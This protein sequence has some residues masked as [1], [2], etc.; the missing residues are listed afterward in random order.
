[1]EDGGAVGGTVGVG[2]EGGGKTIQEQ[3]SELGS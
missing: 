1:V 3:A 2:M